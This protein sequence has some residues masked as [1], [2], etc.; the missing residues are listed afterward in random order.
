MTARICAVMH[1][2]T[3]MTNGQIHGCVDLAIVIFTNV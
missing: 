1:A 3:I 2:K